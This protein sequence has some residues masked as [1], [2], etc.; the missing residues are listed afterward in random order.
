MQSALNQTYK[1]IE[2][3]LVD[4]GSTAFNEKVT[5]YHSKIRYLRKVNGGLLQHEIMGFAQL[6]VNS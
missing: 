1:N 2:V 4:D 3:I 5:P 6:P